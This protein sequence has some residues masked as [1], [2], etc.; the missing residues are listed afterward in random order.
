M[1]SKAN[2]IDD[3]PWM[4]DL[5]T[6]E[7]KEDWRNA[8]ALKVKNEKIPHIKAETSKI[9]IKELHPYLKKMNPRWK[10]IPNEK[11]AT[12]LKAIHLCYCALVKARSTPDFFTK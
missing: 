6:T 3:F 4:G 8:F 2:I 5:P 10:D 1:S 12:S 11:M 9:D 7:M